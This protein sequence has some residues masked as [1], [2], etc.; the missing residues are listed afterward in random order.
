[1]SVRERIDAIEAEIKRLRG[2]PRTRE[3]DNRITQLREQKSSLRLGR[4]KRGRR[5]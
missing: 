5:R 3:V 2:L 4:L 1:M